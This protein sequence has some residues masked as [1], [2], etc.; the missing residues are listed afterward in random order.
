MREA[1][2]RGLSH[3]L[4]AMTVQTGCVRDGAFVCTAERV[5]EH[6]GVTGTCEPNGYCSFPDVS[7][8]DGRRFGEHAGP[9]S[10]QCVTDATGDAGVDVDGSTP[11]LDSTVDGSTP[12]QGSK[13]V[14]SQFYASGSKSAA[15][16]A[17]DYAVLRNVGP[18]PVSLAGWSFQHYKT[19]QGWKLLALP[20]TTL[21]AGERFLIRLY[22]DGGGGGESGT[23]LPAHDLAAPD[24]T[25]WNLSTSNG[26]ALAITTTTGL[27]ASCTTTAVVDLVGFNGSPPCREG[28]AGA[29]TTTD[30]NALV[31]RSAGTQDTD[32]NAA[33][34]EL[35][36][37]SP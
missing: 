17:R 26:E 18:T 24:T 8:P 9:T 37:P 6:F 27:L 12:P 28:A 7:C 22:Y 16:Y 4:I 35:A 15:A 34:F 33:D 36:A 13:V 23:T 21:P 14:I 3:V 1:S 2:A 32:D 29:G 30:T 20:S 11:P 10:G 19:G 5:C 31:R 25:D